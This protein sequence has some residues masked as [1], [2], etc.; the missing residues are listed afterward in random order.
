MALNILTQYP[1]RLPQ[2]CN[3]GKWV[4]ANYDKNMAMPVK[5]GPVGMSRPGVPVF[6][7]VSTM[8]YVWR[9]LSLI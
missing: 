7:V 5:L 8:Q 6:Q 9:R 1:L 3:Y 2:A 4:T